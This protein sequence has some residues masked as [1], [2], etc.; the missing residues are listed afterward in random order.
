MRTMDIEETLDKA[1]ALGW[2]KND[3]RSSVCFLLAVIS[4]VQRLYRRRREMKL[5]KE[6][7]GNLTELISEYSYQPELT[8]KLD[9]VATQDF[10]QALINEIV[11]WKVNRYAPL[12]QST[13]AAL[14]DLSEIAMG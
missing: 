10:D 1:N 8:C 6:W 9:G 2:Q 14:N 12:S 3:V 11:L 13:L 5:A 4:S 7:N